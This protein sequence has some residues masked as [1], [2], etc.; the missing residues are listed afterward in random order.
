MRHASSS[1]PTPS[2]RSLT[3]SASR[4]TSGPAIERVQSGRSTSAPRPSPR[5]LDVGPDPATLALYHELTNDGAAGSSPSAAPTPP[6]GGHRLVG[7]KHEWTRLRTAWDSAQ[8]G[9]P[10]T[11]IVTGE[12]GVGK[13]RLV[14]ELRQHCAAASAPIGTARSY[15][16]ERTLGNSVVLSWLRSPGITLGL[17]ELRDDQRRTLARLLPELGPADRTD[18]ADEAAERR[19]LVDAVARA[20]TVSS[21]PVLLIADDAQWSDDASIELIHHVIRQ[22]FDVAVTVVL[23]ARFED[24]DPAHPLVALRDELAALE[25]LT[26]L[27]LKRLPAAATIELGSDLMRTALGR[28]AGDALFAESEGNPLVVTEMVR[29]GWDGTG[30]V[31]ISPRLRAVIDARFRRAVPCRDGGARRGC[32]RR[33]PVLGSD[34]R[35]RR[36]RPGAGARPRRGR[37]MAQG[38]PDRVGRRRVRVQPRQAPRGGVRPRSDR[39]AA[40]PCTKQPPGPTSRRRPA[41]RAPPRVA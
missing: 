40:A 21:K 39:P 12:A 23:T 9:H 38:D 33:P 6:G 1:E 18:P 14:E 4:P 20:L 36:R 27:R 8:P 22:P 11:V 32:R 24:V 31:A 30:P 37:A 5:E 41:A 26:E 16:G 3:G 13:T 7:R 28:D 25:R 17:R 10:T 35:R 19:R 15:E 2:T 29:S 34:A